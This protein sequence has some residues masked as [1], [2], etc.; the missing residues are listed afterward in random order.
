MYLDWWPLDHVV[1]P[2]KDESIPPDGDVIKKRGSSGKET[3]SK[4]ISWAK[5]PNKEVCR[6]SLLAKQKRLFA[7]QTTLLLCPEV[8]LI[9]MKCRRIGIELARCKIAAFSVPACKV[10]SMA[11]CPTRR[12]L[13]QVKML[14]F[15]LMPDYTSCSRRTMLTAAP[16]CSQSNMAIGKSRTVIRQ[17]VVRQAVVSSMSR[18]MLVAFCKAGAEQSQWLQCSSE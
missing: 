16:I 1:S 12:L 9:G 5:E 15:L 8:R 14:I 7:I 13:H 2:S 11:F 4:A 6:W 18:R 17:T 3:T 10:S